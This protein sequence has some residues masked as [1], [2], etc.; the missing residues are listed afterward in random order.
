[1]LNYLTYL[2]LANIA[3]TGA[4]FASS[5]PRCDA[6]N[7]NNLKNPNQYE[8]YEDYLKANGKTLGNE[9]TETESET[10]KKMDDQGF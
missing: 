1:M 5:C 3:F 2:A 4:I 7:A 9:K 10:P 8:Y 6:A